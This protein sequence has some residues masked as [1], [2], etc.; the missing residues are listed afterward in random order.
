MSDFGPVDPG[1]HAD[2]EWLHRW[3]L[4]PEGDPQ[5]TASSTLIPVRTID[6]VAAVLK[7][8]HVEEEERGAELLEQL[9]GHGAARVLQREGQAVL[10][11]RA[12]GTGDLVRMVVDGDDDG[13]TRVICAAARRVHLDPAELP[14]LTDSGVPLLVPLEQWFRELFAHADDLDPLHRQGADYADR[15]LS[16]QRDARVLHGD[17]HHG[18]VLDF[19]E[20]GW[21]VIDPKGLV[22]E[23]AFDYCNLLCNPSHA[24]ALMPG[25][26]ERQFGIV[27]AETGVLPSRQRDWLVAWC[28]LSSTWFAIADD[29]SHAESV[30][31]LGVTAADLAL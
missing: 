29:P 9:D 11:E 12:T 20:R 2:I 19:G 7:V 21:L 25:R 26:L 5:T 13:A 22:G 15:L 6:G 1:H 30:T 18:N 14:T 3:R 10:L 27:V 23:A 17:L 16:T 31:R 4:H 8:A 24:R 28:A